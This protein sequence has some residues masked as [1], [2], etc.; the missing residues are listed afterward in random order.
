MS[1][2]INTIEN[3]LSDRGI[4]E[5]SAYSLHPMEE[6]TDWIKDRNERLTVRVEQIG[7]EGCEPWYYDEEC[8]RC[9]PSAGH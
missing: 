9:Y 5:E 3:L 8:L 4:E 7:L 2:G 6:L 1:S